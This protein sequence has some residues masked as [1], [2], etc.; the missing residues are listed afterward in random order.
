[1]STL[2]V[3]R[4]FGNY[5]ILETVKSGDAGTTFRVSRKDD[6]REFALKLLKVELTR[7]EESMK[8]FLHEAG[9]L[10]NLHHPN[11]VSICDSGIARKGAAPYL[12]TEWITG[13][14]LDHVIKR[15][16]LSP[17]RAADI[18]ASLAHGLQA[19]HQLGIFHRDLQPDNII[20]GKDGVS[21]ILDFSIAQVRPDG[22]RIT[23]TGAVVG[24]TE[25]MS[26]EQ[27][28]GHSADAR[29]DVYGLGCLLYAMLTGH[30]PFE[31]DNVGKSMAL[32]V[33]ADRSF[34]K[35][36]LQQV[37]CPSGLATIVATMLA[38][39]ADQRYQTM[40]EVCRALSSFEKGEPIGPSIRVSKGVKRGAIVTLLVLAL[41]PL[42]YML[43]ADYAAWLRAIEQEQQDKERQVRDADERNALTFEP[44]THPHYRHHKLIDFRL[45]PGLTYLRELESK[46][47]RSYG[48][49]HPDGNK[50][51]TTLRFRIFPDGSA[52][53]VIVYKSS[54][55]KLVDD[56]VTMTI[57]NAAPFSP[58]RTN[59]DAEVA[60]EAAEDIA[61]GPSLSAAG[62]P[63]VREADEQLRAFLRGDFPTDRS[64]QRKS[65]L[66]EVTLPPGGKNW[67]RLISVD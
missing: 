51:G 25:Y 24:T 30:S 35:D 3:V 64:E 61:D 31:S 55:N 57:Y 66:I 41:V 21:R 8:R 58:I 9:A 1:M 11:I 45:R 53:D 29:T 15:G 10:S 23:R 60:Q 59:Y 43:S 2:E 48:A 16:A 62:D 54:G 26:P 6:G 18:T 47:L 56:A 20:I 46:I 19:A 36:G 42:A 63:A 27:Y 28:L 12:V 39:D 49:A 13:E 4:S 22:Q 44:R 33:G 67:V 14:S 52:R 38:R 17:Q 65:A 40:D 32:N 37:N 7:D 5:R 50:A 34:V